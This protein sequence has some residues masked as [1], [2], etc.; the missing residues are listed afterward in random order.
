M[1]ESFWMFNLQE[2]KRTNYVKYAWK[3]ITRI[4]LK[5]I[6]FFM[7]HLNEKRKTNFADNINISQTSWTEKS[8]ITDHAKSLTWRSNAERRLAI[9]HQRKRKPYKL[10]PREK[11]GHWSFSGEARGKENRGDK[12]VS[13]ATRQ[14]IL[15]KIVLR[16]RKK[17]LD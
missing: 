13:S 15:Q 14:D 4:K 16:S 3:N 11:E 17:P 2:K 12:G 5:K 1:I 8:S 7:S 9:S 10:T 6:P